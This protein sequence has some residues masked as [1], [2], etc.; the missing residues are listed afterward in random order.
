LPFRP[1]VQG[2][3][4][5]YEEALEDSA[6]LPRACA[7]ASVHTRSSISAATDSGATRFH[8]AADGGKLLESTASPERRGPAKR[9]TCSTSQLRSEHR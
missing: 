1:G 9:V 8:A 5:D 7:P 4:Q 6:V 2:P 3:D